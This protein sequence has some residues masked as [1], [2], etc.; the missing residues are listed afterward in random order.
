[1]LHCSGELLTEAAGRMVSIDPTRGFVDWLQKLG[2]MG[3][4]KAARRI[5]FAQSLLTGFFSNT[6]CI[7]RVREKSTSQVTAVSDRS[8]VSQTLTL[9][10]PLRW[11]R[12]WP[13][14]LSDLTCILVIILSLL[15]FSQ[16][17]NFSQLFEEARSANGYLLE[18]FQDCILS[19]KHKELNLY[20]WVLWPMAEWDK[21]VR[22][23]HFGCHLNSVMM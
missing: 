21:S 8:R 17:T 3:D 13:S 14:T 7:Y 6:Y 1:M 10:L 4:N 12:K 11:E 22:A 23:S 15:V 9:R 2:R 20:F 5:Y 18:L 16:F 19:R